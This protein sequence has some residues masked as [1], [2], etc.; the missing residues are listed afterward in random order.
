MKLK[1][2]NKFWS[3][4]ALFRNYVDL[5]ELISEI[6]PSTDEYLDLIEFA[7]KYIMIINQ[8]YR[9]SFWV[10]YNNGYVFIG[11]HGREDNDILFT[12]KE[13]EDLLCTF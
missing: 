5:T 1:S 6:D 13:H 10:A 2:P 9:K 11:G 12:K 3:L 8:K 4:K 7:T